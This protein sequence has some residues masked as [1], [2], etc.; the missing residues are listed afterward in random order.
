LP[1]R[2]LVAVSA[3]AALPRVAGLGHVSLW[4]D[5]ILGTLQASG[6]FSAGLAAVRADRVHPPG[7]FLLDWSWFQLTSAEPWRRLLPVILGVL[8]VVLLAD[9]AKRWFGASAAVATAL[10]A[11]LS[12]FHVRYSQELRPY[13]AALLFFVLTLWAVERARHRDDWRPWGLV[14][15]GLLGS[16]STLY[17]ALL[18]LPLA[19][20]LLCGPRATPSGH[21]AAVAKLA[22][23]TAIAALPLLPWVTVTGAALEK[24]HEL[25]ATNWSLDLA[26]RRWEFLTLAGREG[27]PGSASSLVVAAIALVGALS[28]LRTHVGRVTVAGALVGTFGVELA[29]AAAGHW[30]NGRYSVLAW[31]FLVL[32]VASGCVA[33]GA[34]PASLLR[35]RKDGRTR[36]LCER[37]GIALATTAVATPMLA[38]LLWYYGSGRPDWR[39][40]AAAVGA[41]ESD[42][43]ILVSN[44]WTRVALGYYLARLAPGDDSLAS[45]RIRTLGADP[46]RELAAIDSS[47]A[48]LVEGG[49]PERKGL[50]RLTLET[51]LRVEFPRTHARL[52][53]LAGRAMPDEPDAQ[54]RCA[55]R[56]FEATDW[57]RPPPLPHPRS[58][59]SPRGAAAKR[60]GMDEA[61]DGAL[62]FGWSY[63]ERSRDG[64]GY[65]WAVGRWAA[66]RLAAPGATTLRFE[67]WSFGSPQGV[68][69]YRNRSPIGE[70][71]LRPGPRTFE[72]ALPSTSAT[73]GT[74]VYHLRFERYALDSENPRPLAAGFDWIEV[75]R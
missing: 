21:R 28:A 13:A 73:E 36:R 74:D 24:A 44:D 46:S 2:E 11:S 49:F 64:R 61:S 67:A 66:F 4:L 55:P 59:F 48:V 43:P 51:P 10:L 75:A 29:L 15:L 63:P 35:G 54:W 58:F 7:W 56:P 31:P 72:L 33:C 42:G 39:G 17:I 3:F 37:L 41:V 25:E 5:E 14:A 12:P 27:A 52:A 65:R 18:A 30:S 69:V 9:L 22:W 40:V 68:T 32:L 70:V 62:L 71:D 26:W 60:I 19:L 47:C 8:T 20:A 45:D 57:E 34:A 1:L 16:F 23:A 50:E 38:G 6:S 53:V